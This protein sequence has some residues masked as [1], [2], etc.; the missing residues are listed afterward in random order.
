MINEVYIRLAEKLYSL[1]DD[2]VKLKE[3][4][5]ENLNLEVFDE[6]AMNQL[7][8]LLK[9]KESS[10]FIIGKVAGFLAMEQR[11]FWNVKP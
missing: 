7:I 5:K 9:T 1:K 8:S 2:D 11:A 10:D 4:V 6:N 3:Y